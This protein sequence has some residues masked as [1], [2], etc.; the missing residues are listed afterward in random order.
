MR[1]SKSI[2]ADY[3]SG[4]GSER[5]S[6]FMFSNLHPDRQEGSSSSAS[7]SQT[8]SAAVVE[9]PIAPPPGV[10]TTA[11][12]EDD[13]IGPPGP[14]LPQGFEPTQAVPSQTSVPPP[15]ADRPSVTTV[16]SSG[17]DPQ[18]S[19]PP[20]QF[21]AAQFV[22]PQ[23]IFQPPQSV[24]TMR[25]HPFATPPRAAEPPVATPLVYASQM[26]APGQIAVPPMVAGPPLV[27]PL[28]GPSQP[29]A[30]LQVA[31]PSMNTEPLL[32]TLP[33]V[34]GPSQMVTP[35]QVVVPPAVAGP[36]LVT[37]LLG[38]SQPIAPLQVTVPSMAAKPLL[39]T[40]LVPG[41][42]HAATPH[43]IVAPPTVI[44]PPSPIADLV[45]G[46]TNGDSEAVPATRSIYKARDKPN[47]TAPTRVRRDSI[48]GAPGIILTLS[49]S[50]YR[51]EPPSQQES[52][53]SYAG[54]D[55]DVSV[56]PS[57][58]APSPDGLIVP[59]SRE[60]T[61][62][63]MTIPAE[64]ETTITPGHFRFAPRI[65][66]NYRIDRTDFPSWLLERGRL[67]FVLA[68][69]AGE[70]WEKLIKTWLRQERRLGFGLNEQLVSR[71]LPCA[72]VACFNASLRRE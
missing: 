45:E 72:F 11:V 2:C 18:S 7:G 24:G 25:N 10:N 31:V 4:A 9:Q 65:I 63:P 39:T 62:E 44:T 5:R 58:T 22:V 14:A 33:L 20:Q 69:E 8:P 38:P 3:S 6:K 48:E 13:E 32:A 28:L 42:S 50:G 52:L 37:P 70:L 43:H 16:Q 64:P 34:V 19:I 61:E 15:L 29:T 21:D 60:S 47:V 56:T 1:S 12:D 59:S 46:V 66:P 53:T 71:N 55:M 57:S 68:V 54:D 26:V 36:P 67:D 27:T 17:N 23:E 41:S 40:P 30:S 35:S 49:G 51:L